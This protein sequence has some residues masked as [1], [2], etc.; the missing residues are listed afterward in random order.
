MELAAVAG[1]AGLGYLVAR[2]TEK[3]GPAGALKKEGF[4]SNKAGSVARGQ[5][6]GFVTGV[7]AASG[8]KYDSL[9]PGELT[10]IG[11]DISRQ[12]ANGEQSPGAVNG[13]R[14][15]SSA[16]NFSPELDLM[17]K[18]VGGQTYP[19]E[20]RPGLQ[21]TPLGYAREMPPTAPYGLPSP[22]PLE[23]QKPMVEMRSDGVETEP[24]YNN[25][26]FVTSSLTGN[27][28]PSSEFR[29]NNMVP[30]YGGS[31]KQNMTA[32]AN[33]NRLDS[34]TGSGVT[35]IRKKEVETMFNTAQTPYGAPYGLQVGNDF[36]KDRIVASRNRAGERPFEP[37]RVAPGVGEKGGALGNGGFQQFEVDEIMKRALP[38]TDKLRTAD[39]PKLS[40]D[41]PVVPGQ[42]FIGKAMDNPG[43]VRHYR[44]DRF[45]IDEGGDH[46][47]ATPAGLVKEA[48]RST[49]VIKHTDR[50]E[51]TTE[52][53]G[54]PANS[55][56]FGES[57][58]SG[59]YRTPMTNQYG[60]AGYRNAN[61]TEYYTPYIDSPEAD[62][63]KKGYENKPNERSA[64]SERT[65][66]LNLV[67]ADTGLGIVH[68][69]DDAR[70]TRRG[71]TI[72]TLRQNGVAT[73]YAN[74][75]AP[76]ITVWD[77][78][79]VARTTV[80]ETTIDWNHFGNAQ[81]SSAPARLKVYDPMDVARPTQKAQLSRRSY[82][83]P[84]AATVAQEFESR[85][86]AYNMWQSGEKEATMVRPQPIAGNGGI[87][88]FTGEQN[89]VTFRKL[90]ADI[91]NDRA[92][93][94]NRVQGITPGAADLGQPRL[95][96]PLKLDQSRERFGP[97]MVTAVENNPLNQSLRRNAILDETALRA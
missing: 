63:G 6:E 14:V 84:A 35:Q 96:V 72:G 64:T 93:A 95:R 4:T 91:V 26:Q 22:S 18:N 37:T 65:V 79:N 73:A 83:G 47:S 56:D 67:P 32:T 29:H 2:A 39:N 75:E 36:V 12:T 43:E 33:Q 49:Q 80:K 31:I 52:L 86:A 19:S 74:T 77:R 68:Y 85:D 58:V 20:P 62:Y 54:G 89:N 92:M 27:K 5:S 70:P 97:E 48:V 46:W 94:V 41:K 1:L 78:T 24:N 40:Y 87:A 50:S 11:E 25:K 51:T 42:H 34:Y 30:F 7:Q 60:G 82:T 88:V 76:A 15:G 3:G 69:E 21:G 59:A 71:E 17:Y 61:M 8:K 13:R 57:Y 28:I 45:Y 9:T 81:P 90:D 38:T 55:Q 53:F 66:G 10:R 44:P 16:V 23:A